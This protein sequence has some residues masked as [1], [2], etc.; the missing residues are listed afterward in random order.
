MKEEFTDP[1]VVDLF[2]LHLEFRDQP[3][4]K[5]EALDSHSEL[6]NEL[7]DKVTYLKH[8]TSQINLEYA[9][10]ERQIMGADKEPLKK[11]TL[12]VL[13]SAV[14]CDVEIM[15]LDNEINALQYKVN[16]AKNYSSA[17][18]DKKYAIQGGIE[19]FL[20]DYFSEPVGTKRLDGD[21]QRNYQRMVEEVK[22]KS[23]ESDAR[24][25]VQARRKKKEED[26]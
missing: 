22:L 8:R 9:T 13:K 16:I 7:T 11:P 5:R 17:I 25:K 6:V 2:Q 4:L 21:H 15:E 1:T 12:P 10:G 26:E 24:E 19:L 14:E 20:A 18:S 23:E 3:R